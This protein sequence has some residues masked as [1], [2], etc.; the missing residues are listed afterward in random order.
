L[1]ASCY[2]AL[3][4]SHCANPARSVVGFAIRTNIW[5]T[6]SSAVRWNIVGWSEIMRRLL[7]AWVAASG[8]LI[9]FAPSVPSANAQAQEI[10]VPT[11]SME[12]RYECPAGGQCPTTCSIKGNQIFSTANY[13]SVTVFQLPNQVFWF[14]VDTG[15]KM[16]EFVMA[17]DQMACSISGASLKAARATESGTSEPRKRQ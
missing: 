4:L 1:R 7:I 14:R 8:A 16:V 17:A 12:W 5:E 15:D 9:G 6:R 13:T 3:I 11:G 2:D 10:S